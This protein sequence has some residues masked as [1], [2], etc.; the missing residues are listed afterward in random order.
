VAGN[1]PLWNGV[2]IGT[3]ALEAARVVSVSPGENPGGSRKSAQEK[4]AA[5]EG[6]FAYSL[7]R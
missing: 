1:S 3:P 2:N 5:G 7:I 4:L 6:H